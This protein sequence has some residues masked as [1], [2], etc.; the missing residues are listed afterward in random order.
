V[1]F[2]ESP[3][4]SGENKKSHRATQAKRKKKRGQHLNCRSRDRGAIRRGAG[5][6]EKKGE[7]R[8]GKRGG[9]QIWK[10]KR[11][12]EKEKKIAKYV[13]SC[14]T[15]RQRGR[16]LLRHRRGKEKKGK[17]KIK[18]KKNRGLSKKGEVQEGGRKQPQWGRKRGGGKTEKINFQ[19]IG[20]WYTMK[21]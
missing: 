21:D 6:G 8:G 19:D 17:S 11:L 9:G 15:S 7:N 2:D 20:H 1:S 14:K 3:E 4:E 16:P 10:C 5:L 13:D 12:K 18:K